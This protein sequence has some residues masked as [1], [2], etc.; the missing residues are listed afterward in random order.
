ML[1]LRVKV[2]CVSLSKDVREGLVATFLLGRGRSSGC[3]P[4][5]PR[6]RRSAIH[7]RKDRRWRETGARVDREEG[8]GGK[9]R[10]GSEIDGSEASMLL[11]RGEEKAGGRELIVSI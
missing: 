5:S 8:C 7:T 2:V 3:T 1:L 4:S 9:G 10:G 6:T 11:R